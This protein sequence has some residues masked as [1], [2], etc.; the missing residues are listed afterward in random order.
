MNKLNKPGAFE[1]SPNSI[2]VMF[3][4][5]EVECTNLTRSAIMVQ[6]VVLVAHEGKWHEI[7]IADLGLDTVHLPTFKHHVESKCLKL[8]DLGL[9]AEKV[10]YELKHIDFEELQSKY[11]KYDYV[12]ISKLHE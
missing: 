4:T 6:T 8:S 10:D 1:A 2:K 3:G 11:S 12:Q 5:Q 7:E 9:E